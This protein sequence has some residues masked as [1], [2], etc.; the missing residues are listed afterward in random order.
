MKKYTDNFFKL[1]SSKPAGQFQL[2]MV[3]KGIHVYSNEE[4]HAFLKWEII[5]KIK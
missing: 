3:K 4:P 2:D 5:K 1:F